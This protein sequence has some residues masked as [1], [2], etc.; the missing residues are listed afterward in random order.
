MHRNIPILIVTHN[1]GEH[2]DKLLY[3]LN[4]FGYEQ[5]YICDANST[6][7]TVDSLKKSKYVHQ[8]LFKSQLESFSKN[9]NDL[10]RHFGLKNEYYLILNP[11]TYF[12]TDFLKVLYKYAMEHPKVA[13]ISP[14]MLYPNGEIQKNWKYYPNFLQ[15]V[16]KRVGFKTIADEATVKPGKIDWC[17]G[18][19]MLVRESFIQERGYLFD[20]RY[21][22][23]CEDIDICF[24]AHQRGYDVVGLNS[25]Y[26]YHNLGESSSKQIFNK[27]NYWNV[28]SILKFILKWNRFYLKHF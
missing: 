1:H 3:A 21:R 9:N 11:D 27:Y 18:A 5:A 15:A 17:L 28:Q 13:I 23:Y 12:D 10:I 2:I 8:T 22:L 20:E 7:T 16:S 26:I 19:C 4:R 6:D 14:K 24:D 25:T